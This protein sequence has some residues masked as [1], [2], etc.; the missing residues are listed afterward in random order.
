[1]SRSGY[2]DDLSQHTLNLYRASVRRSI[3]GKRGQAFL[4]DLIAALDAMPEKRLIQGELVS[5][6][7]ECCAIGAVC[8]S[9]GIDTTNVDIDDAENVGNLVNIARPMAA[10]IEYENDEC[11]HDW[12]TPET[13]EQRW[14][15]MRKWAQDRLKADS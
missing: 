3:F 2:T 13:P 15:R 12:P 9:R 4:R 11:G 14:T 5:H 6:N 8:K 10:E 1:M 7:G